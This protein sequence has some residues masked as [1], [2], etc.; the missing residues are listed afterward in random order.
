[1]INDM[2]MYAFSFHN[3][4]GSKHE[5][6]HHNKI[7]DLPRCQ[8]HCVDNAIR[9]Y[10]YKNIF[11]YGLVTVQMSKI[12]FIVRLTIRSFISQFNIQR[13][14]ASFPSAELVHNSF[15]YKM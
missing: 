13:F 5:S 4:L 11:H 2:K 6:Q 12:D 9:P 15:W 1:M 14:V 3:H 8:Q 7:D 10:L